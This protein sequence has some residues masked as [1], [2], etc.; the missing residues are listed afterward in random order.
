MAMERI[1]MV[2]SMFRFVV[3]AIWYKIDMGANFCQVNRIRPDESLMPWVTSG[4]QK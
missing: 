2:R 3:G 4:T 1:D